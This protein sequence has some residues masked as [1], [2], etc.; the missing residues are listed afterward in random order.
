MHLYL[1]ADLGPGRAAQAAPACWSK[2]KKENTNTDLWK[3]IRISKGQNTWASVNHGSAR[4]LADSWVHPCT[5]RVESGLCV[6]TCIRCAFLRM[7]PRPV[8][9]SIIQVTG[10][11]LQTKDQ[12]TAFEKAQH[13]AVPLEKLALQLSPA[14]TN[15]LKL[16]EPGTKC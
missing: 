8:M 9:K 2:A 7:C 11:K 4:F 14:S 12:P 15:K 1:V 3:V 16:A 10:T 13:E 6:S 5:N